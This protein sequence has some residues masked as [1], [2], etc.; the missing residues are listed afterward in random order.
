[1]ATVTGSDKLSTRIMHS[2]CP[3]DCP[4]TCAL[5]VHVRDGKVVKVEGDPTHPM[6][7]GFLCAKLTHYPERLYSTDRLLYPM[8]RVGPKGE[9]RFARV[10]WEEA[11]AAIAARISQA[12]ARFGPESI[13]PYSYCGTEGV[14][15]NMSMDRRF[16]H[17]LGASLL[18]RTICAGAGKVAYDA[19]MGEAVSVDPELVGRA[20]LLINWGGNPLSTSIHFIPAW[21]QARRNGA[22]TIDINVHRTKMSDEADL[23]LQPRPGTDAALALGLM[24]LIVRDGLHDEEYLRSAT[25]GFE[26]L[27]IRLKDYPPERVTAITGI[28]AP[29]LARLA[30]LYA[31][32]H[33]ALIRLGTGLQRHS[34]GG[35]THRAVLALPALTGAWRHVGG[36]LLAVNSEAAPLNLAA[37]QRPDFM[38]RRPRTI[39][40]VELGRV[41]AEAEPPVKVLVVYNSNPLA[42]A[43]NQNR[44]LAGLRRDDLFI[45]VHEQFMTETARYADILLPATMMVEHTDLY[46]SNRH[47]YLMLGEQVVEPPGECKS[48]MELFRLLAQAM[49]FTEAAFSDRDEE[50]I[51]QALASPQPRLRGVTLER[52]RREHWVKMPVPAAP[53]A[54]GAPRTPSGKIELYAASLAAQGL[55]PLPAYEPLAEGADGAPELQ[56]RFPIQLINASSKYF[57]NSSFANLPSM[58]RKAKRPVIQLHPADAAARGI[59]DGDLVRVFNERGACYLYAEVVAR[60]QAGVAMAFTTWWSA[61]S[62]RGASLNQLTSDRLADMGGGAT[63]YTNLVQIEPAA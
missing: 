11:I 40:M 47:Q 5:L 32:T 15:A 31:T 7:Q 38:P 52:L 28:A 48:N 8:Q 50:L 29:L 16:F 56:A 46:R 43:P 3:H 12:A 27:A 39:N 34:N 62:P 36:G 1:M 23:F 20:R 18:N 57:C 35:A 59:A 6:T 30:R 24:H 25:V 58:L 13:L 2:V 17:R 60:T 22:V 63:F 37:L 26:A 55:D 61:H 4:D 53:Y 10:S 21:R 44:V 19:T 54:C 33:P 49:G 14:L 42:A 9:G 51:R 45:A 41:L